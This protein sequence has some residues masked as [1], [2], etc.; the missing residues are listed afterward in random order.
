MYIL[1]TDTSTRASG[2]AL[3]HDGGVVDA[4]FEA[5][6]AEVSRQLFSWVDL[7]FQR[8]DMSLSDCDV[9]AVASGPGS[10]TG[11]RVGLAAVKAWAEAYAKPIAAIGAL[12][13]IATQAA[14]QSGFVAAILD[15]RQGQVF[16]ALFEASKNGLLPSGDQILAPVSAFLDQASRRVADSP[17][18]IATPTVE[19]IERAVDDSPLRRSMVRGVSRE[20]APWIG[21][22][23]YVKAREGKLVDA[24]TLDALYVRHSDAELYWKDS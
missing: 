8:N 7:I 2:V 16:G 14:P 15:A 6:A 9:F 3:L 10:F 5:S 19:L 11:L 24:M 20:L 18:V 13:A 4:V 1:S 23:A 21:R 17:V 22:L 12:E